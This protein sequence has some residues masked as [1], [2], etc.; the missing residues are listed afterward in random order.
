MIRPGEIINPKEP[1]TAHRDVCAEHVI[2]G[3]QQWELQ[4]HA[5]Q[6]L[7]RKHR[8]YALLFMRIEDPPVLLLALAFRLDCGNQRLHARLALIHLALPP[9]CQAS[10]WP[11][12]G[13]HT[14]GQSK[15]RKAMAVQDLHQPVQK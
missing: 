2:G 7:Q 3:E 12:H 1:G 8:V 10:Q 13:L 6:A 14:E 5:E 11:H 15:Y 4:K 9:I